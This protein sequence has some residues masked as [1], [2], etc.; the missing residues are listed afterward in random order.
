[1]LGRMLCRLRALAHLFI[2]DERGHF[3]HELFGGDHAMPMHIQPP[4]TRDT[5][6]DAIAAAEAE[7]RKRRAWQKGIGSNQLTAT[8]GVTTELT[9]TRMLTSGQ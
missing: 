7:Q 8:G 3:V 1:M 4:P 2:A 6:A 5:A 9:G